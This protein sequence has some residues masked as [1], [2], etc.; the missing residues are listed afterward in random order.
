ME[1]MTTQTKEAPLVINVFPI[2]K[3]KRV[4]LFLADFFICF[5]ISFLLFNVGSYPIGYTLIKYDSKQNESSEAS[6]NINNILYGNELMY[7][8]D[9][10]DVNDINKGLEYTFDLFIN[11]IVNEVPFYDS[12]SHDVFYSYYKGMLNDED[13]YFSFFIQY[14]Q[15]Y[16]FFDVNKDARTIT[17]SSQNK[18][19]LS[20]LKVNK[21]ALSE[22]GVTLYNEMFNRFFLTYYSQMLIDINVND[23]TFAGI[24]YA[25]CHKI[26]E[27]NNKIMDNLLIISS[28]AAFVVG[29][30][31]CYILIPLINQ[32]RKTIGMMVMKI[33]RIDIR[34]M[35]IL[36]H[37]QISFYSIYSIFTNLVMLCFLP[38]L[39]MNVE[40]IFNLM[41]N[42]WL[43]I[44][45]LLIII[46]S[47]LFL[48]I[49]KSNQSLCDS[50]TRSAYIS[51][52]SLD[53]IFRA[54]G[55]YI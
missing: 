10:N 41:M 2:S 4:L 45:S 47:L 37:K 14:N 34:S 24:S 31:V 42:L 27:N 17:I 50:A 20:P 3:G 51:N 35:R 33:N 43:S 26:I 8:K 19:L 52:D 11:D 44:A 46:V 28:V 18:E 7:F 38:L 9:P 6:L 12:A 48:L 5:L 54:R 29:W 21:D 40:Y 32:Y 15:K 53:E 16:S 1:E 25:N 36:S 55:Y 39:V 23:L 13:K 49:S 22:D 30:F